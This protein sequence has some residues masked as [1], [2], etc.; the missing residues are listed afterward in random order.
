M[1]MEVSPFAGK[2]VEAL[3]LVNPSARASENIVLKEGD[4]SGVVLQSQ[5]QTFVAQKQK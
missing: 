3:V 2:P 4:T 1:A 5:A